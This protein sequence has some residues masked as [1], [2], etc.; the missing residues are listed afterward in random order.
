MEGF[1]SLLV[2]IFF[3]MM[4]VVPTLLDRAARKA[5][6]RAAL[7]LAERRRALVGMAPMGTVPPPPRPLPDRRFPVEYRS[8][9]EIPARPISL[10]EALPVLPSPLETS[11]AAPRPRRA[12]RVLF[13]KPEDV[14][15]AI[16]LGTLL[17]PPRGAD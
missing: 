7:K 8:L 5:Q 16:L 10:E 1:V 12:S 4:P 11:P 14:R 17:G 6:Q 15:R 2:V 3:L 13:E 9:E